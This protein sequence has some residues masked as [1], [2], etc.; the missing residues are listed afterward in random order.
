MNT[1]QNKFIKTSKRLSKWPHNLSVLS[2][3]T[4]QFQLSVVDSK[5]LSTNQKRR[6]QSDLP[7]TTQSMKFNAKPAGKARDCLRFSLLLVEQVARDCISTQN[8]AMGELFSVRIESALFSTSQI[9]TF[10]Q[11]TRQPLFSSHMLGAKS[12]TSAVHGIVVRPRRN[13][14]YNQINFLLKT[15]QLLFQSR[16]AC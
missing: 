12:L 11:T 10:V 8:K 7:I 13:Q 9:P 3:Y 2:W 16:A 1:E 15:A 4:T 6:S 5:W 14:I